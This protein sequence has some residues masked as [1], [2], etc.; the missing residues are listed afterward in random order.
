MRPGRLVVMCN[1][2]DDTTLSTADIH[3]RAIIN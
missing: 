1:V 3:Q 2:F